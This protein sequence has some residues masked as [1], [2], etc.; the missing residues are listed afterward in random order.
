MLDCPDERKASACSAAISLVVLLFFRDR[1]RR[2]AVEGPVSVPVE[3]AAEAPEELDGG[4]GDDAIAAD[5]GRSFG[6]G[7]T[8]RFTKL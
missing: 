7:G 5:E 2:G 4:G 3:T 1:R 6:T 8:G